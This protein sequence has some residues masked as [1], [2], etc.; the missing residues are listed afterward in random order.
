MIPGW[1]LL[2]VSAGYVGLL[3]AVAYYGDQRTARIPKLRWLRPAVYSLALAVYCSSWTFYGAVGTAARTGLGFLPIYL[4]PLLMLA[5]GWRIL[6]RLVLIS[7]EHRIV[8]IADF[9]SSRYGRAPGLA[10]LVAAVALTAAVPY[11]ALQFKAVAMSVEV[12][13]GVPSDA[14][15]LADPAF[16]VALMLA[17]FAILF[18]TRQIDATEH[19]HGMVLAVALESLVKLVAFV[20]IGLFALAHLP[21]DGSLAARVGQAAH[22][23]TAPGLPPGFVAQ[24]LLA[25]AAILCLPRQ[26]HVAVVE[27]Q[28]PNDLRPARWLFGGY[29]ALISLLVVPITLTGQAVLA[30]S[31]VSP[32]TYVLALPLAL[33]QETLA[34]MVYIGG[35]S[36]ATGMVIVASV[37]LA[38]MVS[39]DLIV[40]LLLRSGAL[41]ET[42][43]IDRQ[44]LWVRRATIL[45][46][47]MMAYAYHRASVGADSLAQHGL[48]AFAAVAQFAPALIGGLY[49][50]GASRAGAFAGLL[51]GALLWLYTLLLPAL[52][53]VGWID[54]GWIEHGPLGVSWLRPEQLFGLTGWDAL[55]HGTFWSLLFNIGAFLF[56]SVRQRPR[57]QEQLLAATYLDPYVQRPALGPGGWAGSVRSGELLTLAERIVGERHARRAFEEYAQARG[58]TWLPDQPADRAL[59]QF[60]ERLLASA[61]GAASARLTLTSA[62]RGSGMELGEVVALLDEANQELRFNRQVLSTTLENISQGVSVV[63]RDMRLVAWNRRYQ[64][65][66]D[67]PDGMLYV[68]RPVSDLIRWNA[69]RGEMGPGDID[70]QVRRRLAH[71][72]AGASHVFERVRAN[73]QVI[74]MV[75]RPLLGGGYVTSYSDVTDYKR[76]EQALREANETLEQR[77]EQRTQE[78][79]AAQQ[80]KTRFLAAVSHDVLQPLNA[81]RLFTT[82]L[83][84]TTDADEQTRLAERVDASLRAAED[85]LDGLL[86]ISRLDAGA[87]RPELT[88]FDAGEL[89]H[90]LAAQ[91]APSAAGRGLQLRV[92]VP[93]DEMPVRSDRRLLRRA[94]QNFIANA[95]RYTREGGVLMA[96]RARDGQVELQVWD[97]GPGIP[98]HH[99]EQIFDEFR[100]FDQPG[101]GGER[102]L[103][104]GLSICQRIARTLDHPLQVRS[105]V[106]R[107]SVFSIAVPCG[108]TPRA[109]GV[110]APAIADSLAGLRV[111]CVDNDLEILDGMRTLLMRWQATALVAA[112]V[113]EALALMDQRPD[114]ALVDF[115]LHDRLDGLG[116]VDALRERAGRILPAA[117]LTGDGSDALKLAARERGCRV[118]T[119]PIKPA[120]LRAFLA[121][122]RQTVQA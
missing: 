121:A 49:W 98:E 43:G 27:C 17:V 82:A 1:I 80:S 15:L 36:A 60:T 62:L 63:D 72:R 47:A 119:K 7:G 103:G 67:Y 58:R 51:A 8:S 81:A 32:D 13:A 25:F 86:D 105:H 10:A 70:A 78:A 37:A 20:A 56:V 4:G 71:L 19:H 22:V 14:S 115:H 59:A 85:L 95:L 50:R 39:N 107:G 34:L 120:S 99:L 113:D 18:G 38:T 102:G 68:G 48:L 26:F 29:L 5:F 100:R 116:V 108:R 122:Q 88:D 55:T 41:R 35:F 54:T 114:V 6:E 9:L 92:R 93:A 96:A 11:V 45:V 23:V 91:Y 52:G 111:L 66:F 30:G 16:Y 101:V 104:L 24:T 46:L 89:L 40:P 44:V 21:G 75:G 76:S 33:K 87:L 28:D 2:L 106:G 94:L 90:E 112:T 69:E 97:T 84:E 110:A 61:I 3:F 109:R 73:G 64:E 77:V 74:E 42:Q 57:L 79:E 53:R 31:S 83:R 118:L 65:L 117:L 12:L